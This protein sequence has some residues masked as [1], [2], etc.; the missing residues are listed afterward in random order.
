MSN[1]NRIKLLGVG[2]ASALLITSAAVAQHEGRR[3]G[4][5]FRHEGMGPGGPR[6]PM[7]V[8][9]MLRQLDLSE[10]Q[11]E[12]IRALFEEVEATGASERLRE[13]RQSLH[14]AIESGADEAALRAEAAEL[15]EAEGDAAVEWARV[16]ARIQEILTPEQKTELE[17]LK[18][19]AQERME[20]IRR[21]REE[22]RARRSKSGADLL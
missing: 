18:K 16:R 10:E 20:M 19:D 6:G 4:R 3:G 21:Q 1:N 9:G 17:E 11:R 12:R 2:L 8:M 22:R 7:A 14:D 15:G 13:A 5:G